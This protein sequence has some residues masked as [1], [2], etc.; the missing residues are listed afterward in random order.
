MAHENKNNKNLKAVAAVSKALKKNGKLKGKNKKE[1]KYLKKACVH[2]YYN[3]NGKIKK[4]FF[5]NN[6]G[7]CICNICGRS[8]PT[9]IETKDTIREYTGI[10]RSYVDQG[11]VAAISGDQGEKIVNKF[12]NL[13]VALAEFAKDY[14]R[15]MKAISKE[16]RMKKKKKKQLPD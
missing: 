8:F 2:H 16:D 10:L 6:D 15:T 11:L 13:N 14:S 3:K 7:K 4:D 5:N 12:V 9:K 1:T